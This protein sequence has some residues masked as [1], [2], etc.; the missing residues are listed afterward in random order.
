MLRKGFGRIENKRMTY[1][2][3]E[4]LLLRDWKESDIPSFA[5]MNRNPKVMEY[6]L[7]QLTK[8]ESLDFYNRIQ[9]E[10]YEY[11]YGLYAVEKKED[12]SFLG[13]TGFHNILF[14]FD[15]APGI[16]IGWRLRYKDWNNGYATEAAKACLLY[17]R[18]LSFDTIWSFTSLLNKASE[19]VMQKIG[20][21]KVK[22]FFH[23]VVP[24]DHPLKQ[25]ILYKIQLKNQYDDK[26]Y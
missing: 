2:E 23:P 4:R 16:E 19:Q 17:A 7:K 26:R 12:G 15:F 8:E 25:H 1:I 6:F 22:E 3:T 18:H 11:G 10:F 20:M 14:D 21:K 13:Y 5:E 9:D 24:N